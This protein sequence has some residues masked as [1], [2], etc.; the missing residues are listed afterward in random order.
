MEEKRKSD[1]VKNAMCFV[2][3]LSFIIYF[4]EKDKSERVVKN[5]KY[6]MFLF[7]VFLFLPI[8]PF[9]SLWFTWII[10]ILISWYLG[11]KSYIWEDVDF[12]FIDKIIK[13]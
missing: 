4:V 10:Y 11:Y 5:S 7:I 6:W 3:I 2:P 9:L 8:L 1:K 13:K 12:D